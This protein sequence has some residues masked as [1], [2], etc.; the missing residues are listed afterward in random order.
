MR[1]ATCAGVPSRCSGMRCS[2]FSLAH[3]RVEARAHD[4]GRDAVHADV[5]IGELAR[6]GAGEMR[7]RTLHDLIRDVRM[8]GAQPCGRGDK[9]DGS[10]LARLHVR[11]R[12]AAEVKDGV[13]VD[14][15]RAIPV[16]GRDLGE[17]AVHRTAGGMHKHVERAEF[18]H[19]FLHATLRV[20]RLRAIGHDDF[21]A[22]TELLDFL[23]RGLRVGVIETSVDGDIR[24][25]FGE[26]DGGGRADT[27][28][29]ASDEGDFVLEGHV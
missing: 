20:I 27:L 26:R 17:L 7:N 18:L 28:G 9:D 11:Q 25:G 10:L 14:V 1:L 29:A 16:V 4:A 22:A 2:R 15:E 24:A 13:D 8:H 3:V 19:R 21:A 12:G 23:S 6:E 5:V